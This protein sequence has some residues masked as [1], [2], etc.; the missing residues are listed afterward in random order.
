MCHNHFLLVTENVPSA[1]TICFQPISFRDFTELSWPCHMLRNCLPHKYSFQKVLS[2]WGL[3]T[4]VW[5]VLR[6]DF[7]FLVSC[8]LSQ[9]SS[10]TSPSTDL[11]ISRDGGTWQW[12]RGATVL[13]L[14]NAGMHLRWHCWI[15]GIKC[16]YCTKIWFLFRVN[17]ILSL[18][19]HCCPPPNPWGFRKQNKTKKNNTFWNPR[20]PALPEEGLTKAVG[21]KKWEQHPSHLERSQLRLFSG[22]CTYVGDPPAKSRTQTML[23]LFEIIF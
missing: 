3:T 21:A 9:L 14:L 18:T 17:V 12:V 22:S 4:E 11:T 20:R 19:L 16:V 13:Y 7:L 5:L 1:W 8:F 2:T 15:L 23:A 10:K 6:G